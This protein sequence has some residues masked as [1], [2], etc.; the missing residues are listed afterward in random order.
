MEDNITIHGRII[1]RHPE[2]SPED[3]AHAWGSRIA[4]GYR[5]AGDTEQTVAVGF[6]A[7]GRMIEMVGART[8]SGEMIV[9]HAM[10]PPS[11]KTMKE[12]RLI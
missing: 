6:D 10:T 3:I 5:I 7:R 11:T 4:T 9:F 2:L 8:S 12:T 1:E